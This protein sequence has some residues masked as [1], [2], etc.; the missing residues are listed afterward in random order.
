MVP[1]SEIGLVKYSTA[2]KVIAN[3]V[4]H[5]RL[6]QELATSIRAG[7]AQNHISGDLNSMVIEH[8]LAA[9]DAVTLDVDSHPTGTLLKSLLFEESEWTNAEVVKCLRFIYYHMVNKFK[10]NLAEFL[11]IRP[12]TQLVQDWKQ[13][14]LLPA[15]ACYVWGNDIKEQK[16]SDIDKRGRQAWHKGADGLFIMEEPRTG[17]SP[18]ADGAVRS[19]VICGVVEVKSYRL[20][21]QHVKKQMEKHLARFQGGLK[22]GD[23]EWHPDHLYFGKRDAHHRTFLRAPVTASPSPEVFRLL[24]VPRRINEPPVP[25]RQEVSQNTFLIVLPYTSDFFAA[26]AYRMTKWFLC[27]LGSR[28]FQG[29]ANPWPQFTP[30]EAGLNAAKE[31]L[32]HIHKRDLPERAMRIASRLF[33]V[34]GFGYEGAKGHR[35]M[36]WSVRG[37][38]MSDFK[39]PEPTFDVPVGMNLDEIV[40]RAW[41]FYRRCYMK[42]ALAYIDV[43]MSLSPDASVMRRLRWLRGMI[44]YVRAEFEEAAQQFPIPLAMP[45]GESWASDKLRLSRIFVRLGRVDEAIREIEEVSK[46]K[47]P[48]KFLSISIP[49]C[50]ATVSIRQG[51]TDEGRRRLEVALKH[52]QS[53]REQIEERETQGLGEPLHFNPSAIQIA[54]M[55]MATVFVCLGDCDT[56]MEILSRV[57][58]IFPPSLLLLETD[59]SLEPLRLD[60]KQG[61]RFKE[62]IEERH[63]ELNNL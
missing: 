11:A 36:I 27:F 23:R 57:E 15:E 38:L 49:V 4:G 59:P 31:A 2:D 34:Y 16:T 21:S 29:L 60:K 37:K 42:E 18:S 26:A 41:S 52:L 17:H 51:K 20:S 5:A 53:L 6:A 50:E 45:Q 40:E 28:V 32:Y 14:G 24:A 7:L 33:N 3:I 56:A 62:W 48:Y 22:I 44:H 1:P 55:E 10:G 35:D 19:L 25:A 47:L 9:R 61:P 39:E 43:G 63:K 46:A 58:N 13:A 8:F 54:V 12:C 30:E